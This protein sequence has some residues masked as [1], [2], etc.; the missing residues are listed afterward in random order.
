MGAWGAN[1]FDNDTACDWVYSLEETNDLSLVEEA[2]DNVL[3]LGD[4]YIDSDVASEA[5]AACE[6]IARMKGNWGVRNSYTESVDQWV[7][8]HRV[9]PPEQ[10]VQRALAVIDRIVGEDSELRASWEAEAYASQWH[11]AV[12]DLKQRLRS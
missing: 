2:F 11:A 3:K 8:A 12:N 7:E 4:A 9:K 10:L 5:L 6:V 1:T